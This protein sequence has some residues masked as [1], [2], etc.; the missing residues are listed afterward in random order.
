MFVV[1]RDMI[2]S[3]NHSMNLKLIDV[4]SRVY[5]GMFCLDDFGRNQMNY[6]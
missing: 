4:H 3:R 5:S 1:F 6:T 2:L